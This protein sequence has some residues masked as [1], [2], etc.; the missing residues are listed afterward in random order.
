MLQRN[1]VKIDLNP[2]CSRLRVGG[3]GVGERRE[4]RKEK[5]DSVEGGKTCQDSYNYV[6]VYVFVYAHTSVCSRV[7]LDAYLWPLS[8]YVQ[9]NEACMTLY[10]GVYCRIGGSGHAGLCVFA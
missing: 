4:R 3:E 1:I 2:E 10:T 6:H 9:V 5:G 7:C 8:V